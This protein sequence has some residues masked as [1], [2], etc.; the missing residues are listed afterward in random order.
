MRTHPTRYSIRMLLQPEYST[1]VNFS[2]RIVVAVPFNFAN[3]GYL[4]TALFP[5]LVL[6]GVQKRFQ[7][8]F[9]LSLTLESLELLDNVGIDSTVAALVRSYYQLEVG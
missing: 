8:P 1:L 7:R 3:H 4:A 9:V 5:W 2:L 6:I